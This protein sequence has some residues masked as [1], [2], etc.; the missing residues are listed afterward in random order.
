MADVSANAW[1]AGNI[2][3]RQSGDEGI[4]LRTEK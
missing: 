3:E 1:C 2:I 4:E